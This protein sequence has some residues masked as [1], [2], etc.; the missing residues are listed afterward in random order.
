MQKRLAYF[1][2]AGTHTEQACI[3]YDGVAVRIPFAT[4][5]LVA[6]AVDT[7]Q[8]DEGMVPIENSV[9]GSVSATLD[10]LI[11]ESTLFIRRELVLPI[12]HF[13]LARRD[14]DVRD[15]KVIFSHPQ[16]L[17][18]CRDYLAEHFA[19]AE[20]IASMSTAAAVEEMLKRGGGA[21]AIGTERAS[22]LY[23]TE[24]LARGIEDHPNNM[25]R[26][27]VLAP[28]DS[29]RTGDDKTSI[30]FS[31][32]DDA[33]GILHSVLEEFAKRGINLTKIESRPTREEMGRYIFLADLEG[34][35]KDTIVREALEEVRVQVSLLKVFGSY[36]R[37]RDP[38]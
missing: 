7:G 2:P 3:T 4:I 8:A 24:I 35:R 25:T 14:A 16:A 33:P 6:A 31:F 19:Q 1:G 28:K 17:E 36:P 13:L 34:H 27:V 23:D 9:G 38:L 11:H 18:Q 5:P 32:D 29:P 30:C 37:H 26:F 22:I 21:A 10:L 20:P 15:I 12:K